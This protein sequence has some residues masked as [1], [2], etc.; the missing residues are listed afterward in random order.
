MFCFKIALSC[1][2]CLAFFHFEIE[3]Y[4]QCFALFVFCYFIQVLLSGVS[5]VR[6][7]IS[8]LTLC[9]VQIALK[10]DAFASP[11]LLGLNPVRVAPHLTSKLS[12]ESQLAQTLTSKY[13]SAWTIGVVYTSN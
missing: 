4:L 2:L 5:L 13:L 8:R 10:L 11:H 6:K 9:L 12:Q 7:G 1:C 3:N